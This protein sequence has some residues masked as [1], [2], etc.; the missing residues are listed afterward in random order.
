MVYNLNIDLRKIAVTL[1][2]MIITRGPRLLVIGASI[3]GCD[4]TIG[5]RADSGSIG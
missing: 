4:G 1:I 5:F 2:P 3:D